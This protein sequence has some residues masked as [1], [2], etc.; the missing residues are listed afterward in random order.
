M[1]NQGPR[2]TIPAQTLRNQQSTED[3]VSLDGRHAHDGE[4]FEDM[5]NQQSTDVQVPLDGLAEFESPGGPATLTFPAYNN[6]ADHRADEAGAEVSATLE[7]MRAPET[8]ELAG[9]PCPGELGGQPCPAEL[10]GQPCPASPP[11]SSAGSLVQRSV[12]LGGQTCP[13]PITA[14]ESVPGVPDIPQQEHEDIHTYTLFVG[15]FIGFKNATLQDIEMYNADQCLPVLVSQGAT[16]DEGQHE[17]SD[18]WGQLV[19]IERL[20]DLAMHGTETQFC[21]ITVKDTIRGDVT[22]DTATGFGVS[23]TIEGT[24]GHYKYPVQGWTFSE[25]RQRGPG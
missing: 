19:T 13:A 14:A 15:D 2:W 3:Q 4:R 24:G 16:N 5:R 8:V 18:F 20:I 17:S 23:K 12:Q 7:D 9:P 22:A 25:R 1:A 21:R 6:H 11:R 10:G